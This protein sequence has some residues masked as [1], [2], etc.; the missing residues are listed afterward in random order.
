VRIHHHTVAILIGVFV[1]DA[2]NCYQAEA[3]AVA[4]TRDSLEELL[5]LDGADADLPAAQPTS[6][7]SVP[8]VVSWESLL[9]G[10]AV[11]EMQDAEDEWR[12]GYGTHS[13]D[14]SLMADVAVSHDPSSLLP[15]DLTLACS[16][17]LVTPLPHPPQ[18]PQPQQQPRRSLGRGLSSRSSTKSVAPPGSPF[19]LARWEEESVSSCVAS[20]C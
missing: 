19:S 7:D 3:A 14:V 15:L 17:R 8:E 13:G 6:T 9:E 10:P 12:R 2:A 20:P 16:R 1:V 18:P 11:R 4:T 5:T